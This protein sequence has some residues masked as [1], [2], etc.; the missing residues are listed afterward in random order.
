MTV[1]PAETRPALSPR[2]DVAEDLRHGLR[3]YLARAED[4][5]TQAREYTDLVEKNR[6]WAEQSRAKAAALAEMLDELG[7]DHEPIP[8]TPAAG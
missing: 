1:Q 5:D 7:Y 3:Q 8:V 4:H 2:D 6:Q